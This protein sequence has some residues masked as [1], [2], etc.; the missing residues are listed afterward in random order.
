MSKSIIFNSQEIV[1]ATSGYKTMCRRVVKTPKAYKDFYTTGPGKW[2][3]SK[4]GS[5][6]EIAYDATVEENLAY[7]LVAG[8]HGWDGPIKSPYGQVRDK[9]WVK[10]TFAANTDDNGWVYKADN[11]EWDSFSNISWKSPILMPKSA[12]RILLEITE[13]RVERL[14]EISER[15]AIAEGIWYL[16]NDGDGDIYLRS[17]PS[18]INQTSYYTAKEAFQSLWTLSHKK[19]SWSFNPFVWVIDFKVLEV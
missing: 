15:D 5:F 1:A 3:K 19:Y 11:L 10:E 9:L 6:H 7:F 2:T 18:A 4:T 17:K 14:Q 8:D 13:L 12:S 16:G